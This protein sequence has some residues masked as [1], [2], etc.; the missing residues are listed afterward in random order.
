MRIVRRSKVNAR[1]SISESKP[2]ASMNGT[3]D[4]S[5][6]SSRPWAAAA[7]RR[8]CIRNPVTVAKSPGPN[9]LSTIGCGCGLDGDAAVLDGDAAVLDGDVTVLDGDAAV[10][11][12]AVAVLLVPVGAV[13]V[14]LVLLVLL[15]VADLGVGRV[16][17][18]MTL[19][20]A[21]TAPLTSACGWRRLRSR[22]PVGCGA[23]GWMV[24]LPMVLPYLMV[25][26]GR[27][28][29]LTRRAR[30]TWPHRC[31]RGRTRP[32][33]APRPVGTPGGP[34]VRRAV[35]QQLRSRWGSRSRNN[36]DVTAGWLWLR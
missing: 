13:A 11:D 8:S 36:F 25:Y 35:T 28:S 7:A 15:D 2:A 27:G 12:G 31:E 16:D 24:R 17:V 4:R 32:V 30:R 23:G 18:V 1:A 26:P 29:R 34:D 20:S 19:V 5:T 9:R 22:R 6:I 10:L 21:V 33:E 3:S 14:L